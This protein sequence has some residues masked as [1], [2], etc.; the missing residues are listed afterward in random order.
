MKPRRVIGDSNIVGPKMIERRAEL[1]LTQKDLLARLQ[2]NGLDINAT[3]L[4]EIERQVR[5]ARD[6]EIAA[7]ADSLQI[8]LDNLLRV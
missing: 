8:S 3:A 4:S 6:Y 2:S 7:I 5:A 1:N